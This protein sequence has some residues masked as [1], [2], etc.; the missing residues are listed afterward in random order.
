MTFFILVLSYLIQVYK[1]KDATTNECHALKKVHKSRVI[2]Q[3]MCYQVTQEIDILL[4][5]NDHP[6]ILGVISYWQTKGYLLQL[7]PL[8]DN[9]DL[10]MLWK[11]VK[12]FP[13]GCVAHIAAQLGT[14]LVHIHASRIVY[15]DLKMENILISQGGHVL[16]SDFGLSKRMGKLT[17][18]YT[19]CGTLD[20]IAPE[21]TTGK[22]HAYPCDWWS[23]GVVIFTLATG[24]LPFKSADD[25]VAMCEII[26]NSIPSLQM[27]TKNGMRFLLFFCFS[28]F[29]LL[30]HRVFS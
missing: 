30:I 8:A 4:K 7:L 29:L 21:V 22:G 23:L 9:G 1:V 17:R 26:K 27:V 28:V 6:F 2:K 5:L 11:R 15:R 25:H 20:Y 18:T 13:I 3:K 12:K 16:L 24:K 10:Q 14:A 19:I